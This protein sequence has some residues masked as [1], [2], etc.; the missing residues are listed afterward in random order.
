M[1]LSRSHLGLSILVL[2]GSIACEDDVLTQLVAAGSFQ[3]ASVDFGEVTVGTAKSVPVV[4][5]SEGTMALTIDG[6]EIPDGFTI[7]GL[8][9]PLEGASFPPGATLEFEAVF[10]PTREGAYQGILRFLAGSVTVELPLSGVGTLRALPQVTVDPTTV[11]FGEIPESTTDRRTL[12]LTNSG[13]ADAVVTGVGLSSSGGSATEGT[14]FAVSGTYPLTIPAGGNTTVEL[15]FTPPG[16]A[17]YSDTIYFDVTDQVVAPTVT[18]SGRGAS[19]A[20]GLTCS[21]VSVNFGAVERGSS[22]TELV[23]CTASGGPVTIEA[24]SV[25]DTQTFSVVAPPN[26]PLTLSAGQ[27][28][29]ISVQMEASGALGARNGELQVRYQGSMGTQTAPISLRGSVTEPTAA[30]TSITLTLT[31]DT[32]RTDVDLHL[33]GPGGAPFLY[34]DC[35]YQ[36]GTA[37]FGTRGDVSDDCFLDRDDIDGYGPERI[38]ISTASSGTYRIYVHYFSDNRVGRSTASLEVSLGG[39]TVGTY[40]RPSMD[41]GDMWYVGDIQWSGT[42][43]TFVSADTVTWSPYGNCN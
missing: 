12:T 27:S 36:T 3:P 10:E 1:K 29:Q 19:T 13:T 39:Q 5:S 14:I 43:G 21:P 25:S 42:T 38:N 28:R 11:D 31:W 22:K 40:S 23:D 34:N 8:K 16:A 32:N 2:G 20:G 24:L 37:D 26:L 30:S 15:A 18:V 35:Y 17:T 9:E 33:V 6:F 7:R 41:C 4:M